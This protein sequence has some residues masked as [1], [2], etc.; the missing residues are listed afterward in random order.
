M[1]VKFNYKIMGKGLYATKPYL[2][3]ELIFI[4]TGP[5]TNNPS[6]ESI[7]IGNNRHI[8]DEN[9]IFMNHSFSP[10]TIIEN[11]NVKALID[12]K[13][14]DELTFNYNESEIDMAEPFYTDGKLVC[15]K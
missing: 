5:I 12:I 3:G 1:E 9:G 8:Y 4:L 10:T 15:G 6:R 13:D 7:H 2:S 14:G 11:V